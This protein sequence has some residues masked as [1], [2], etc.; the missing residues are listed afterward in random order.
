MA[1]NT[2]GCWNVEGWKNISTKYAPKLAKFRP[3]IRFLVIFLIRSIYSWTCSFPRSLTDISVPTK[4][5]ISRLHLARKGFSPYLQVTVVPP[6]L[7]SLSDYEVF[8]NLLPLSSLWTFHCLSRTTFQLYKRS[9]NVW[10][11][12]FHLSAKF[13]SL[14]NY[15]STLSEWI[16]AMSCLLIR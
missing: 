9:I 14:S 6:P 13:T 4:I 1:K 15:L 3:R 10:K 2:C 12:R 11:Y 5:A 8:Q 16:D 7:L